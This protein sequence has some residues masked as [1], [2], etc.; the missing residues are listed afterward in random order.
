MTADSAPRRGRWGRRV[1]IIS[2]VLA[3]VCGIAAF[4]VLRAAP[5]YRTA[6]LV[7]T[8]L[9]GN[10]RQFRAVA[11]AVGSAAQNSA[12]G[13]SL[14]LRRFG[15]VCEDGGNRRRWWDRGRGTRRRSTRPRT[16]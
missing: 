11:D 1:L 13:D 3:L 9:V 10:G 8:S 4:F 12:D 14:S 16:P 2:V 6:F 7:D 5:D 15:G